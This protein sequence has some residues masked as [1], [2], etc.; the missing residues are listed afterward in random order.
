MSDRACWGKTLME[1]IE[2]HILKD[3]LWVSYLLVTFSEVR[4]TEFSALSDFQSRW[5]WLWSRY[6][7]WMDLSLNNL[8]KVSGFMLEQKCWRGKV[9][10]SVFC[11]T[12]VLFCYSWLGQSMTIQL[13][14]VVKEGDEHL[15]RLTH[16]E[17]VPT[18][19]KSRPLEYWSPPTD[20]P[21][22]SLP[23]LAQLSGE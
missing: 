9:G 11:I 3:D 12:I 5:T 23:S 19:D 22:T 18:G 15:S 8:A 6:Y 1:E 16:Q 17:G 7:D 14:C 20:A 13:C 10:G 21:S 4:T 2:R